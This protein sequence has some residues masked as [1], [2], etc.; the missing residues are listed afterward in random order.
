MRQFIP[1]CALTLSALL[2]TSDSHAVPVHEWSYRMGGTN[3]NIAHDVAVDGLGNIIVAGT[4]AGT[5]NLGGGAL[6]SVGSY[7]IFLAKFDASGVH[8]WSQRFGN[9][10]L[11]GARAVTVDGAGN[12]TMTG[13]FRAPVS[14]G[15]APLAGRGGLD[16]FVARFDATGAHQWSRWYGGSSNDEGQDIA[17]DG[18]GNV[19]VTGQYAGAADLGSGVNTPGFGGLDAF[20]LK[21]D[22]SG[23]FQWSKGLGSSST[24]AGYGVA[25]D[26]S[27]SIF[28]TGSFSGAVN[29]GGGPL[30]SAGSS[31]IF[32]AK[33]G[34][35]GVHQWSTRIGGASADA[36]NAIA[37]DAGGIIVAGAYNGALLARYDTGGLQ[38]W[39]RSFTSTGA[40]QSMDLAVSSSG[41][42]AVTGNLQGT[43]DLGGGPLTSAGDDDIFLAVCDATGAHLWSQRFGN[44]GD[45]WGHGCAFDAFGNLIGAGIFSASV[46]FGGAAL[47]SAGLSDIY[48]VK[49]DDDT[50]TADTTPPVITCPGNV[51]VVLAGSGGTPAT[52]PAIAAFLSGVSAL[53]DTDPAPVITHNAPAVFP[54]GTT[55][56]TFHAEDASGNAAE[57]TAN[58]SVL[59]TSA[60]Q[61]TVVLDRDR[62]WPPN[63]KL[64]TVCADVTVSDNSGSEPSFALVSITCNES[65][66]GLGDGNTTNDIRGADYG[67][68]D[69]CFD[70]RAERS[71]NGDGRV[72]EIVYS[73][74]DGAGNAGYATAYVHVGHDMW[75]GL[76]AGSQST[77]LTSVHPNPFNPQT[78]VEYSLSA[79][80]RVHMVIY[81]ARGG[82]VR[83]LV[84][85]TLPAGDHRVV[86]NGAD[87]AGRPVASGIYFVKLAVGSHTDTRKIVLLK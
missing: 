5:M 36:G 59:D 28:V 87:Q 15:G 18:S 74:T 23:A 2:T 13:Y 80:D 29:F 79:G 51:Q 75:D 25:V 71:G 37:A 31:D 24:D 30:A 81:D 26:A 85:Q 73:A 35:N 42:I 69:R 8:Q 41:M 33:Y 40:M 4:F 22:A 65:D 60:P 77:K 45:D 72:Y 6:M 63:H 43:A 62:L 39:I 52:D 17:T 82:A 3:T 48:V 46:N 56:V 57:C 50:G 7:D 34:S 53:D 11:D 27:S 83:E 49:F 58:V 84:N 78:T 67:T 47:V 9:T 54:L 1:L 10:G 70:L 76:T 68:P 19:V 14:F 32:I 55:A 38:Q 66:N 21:V 16:I 12:I 61:I 44:T 86:W 20:I 64:V